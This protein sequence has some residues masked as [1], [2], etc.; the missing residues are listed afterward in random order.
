MVASP[1]FVDTPLSASLN[2]RLPFL[3]TAERAASHIARQFARAK[4]EIVFPWQLA[5]AVRLAACLPQR[6]VD[7]ILTGIGA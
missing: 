5:L 7:R 3:W 1:G 2:R 6:L 4:R